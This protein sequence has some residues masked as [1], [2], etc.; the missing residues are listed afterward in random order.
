MPH[1]CTVSG[2]PPPLEVELD[3]R[4]SGVTA[5]P[6]PSA[7]DNG[8]AGVR[9]AASSGSPVILAD[10]RLWSPDDLRTLADFFLHHPNLTVPIEPF[11]SALLRST[12]PGG[13]V[14]S[15]SSL[16][17]LYGE[18]VPV[19]WIH[20]ASLARRSSSAAASGW[21]PYRCPSIA[22]RGERYGKR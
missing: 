18:P 11:Y 4:V 3:D 17:A 15:A 22:A 6:I 2:A 19:M 7:P 14:Q 9:A 21:T 5:A 20:R 1:R 12:T 8:T 10:L 13:G 16:R